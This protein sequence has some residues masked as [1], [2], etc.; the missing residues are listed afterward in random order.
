M[1]LG[2]LFTGGSVRLWQETDPERAAKQAIRYFGFSIT[3]L[4]VLFAALAVDQLLVWGL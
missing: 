4:T 2:A 3:H 1:V